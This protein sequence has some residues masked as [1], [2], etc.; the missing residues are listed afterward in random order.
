[1]MVKQLTGVVG[2]LTSA[3]LACSISVALVLNRFSL[4]SN[5][6]RGSIVQERI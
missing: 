5:V 6:N 4:P 2:G 3:T 1:M